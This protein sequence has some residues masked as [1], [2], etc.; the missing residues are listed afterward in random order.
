MP[1]GTIPIDL[2][3]GLLADYAHVVG[4]NCAA[5]EEQLKAVTAAFGSR[6]AVPRGGQQPASDASG[7]RGSR[8]P[9]ERSERRPDARDVDLRR[10]PARGRR[11]GTEAFRDAATAELGAARLPRAVGEAGGSCAMGAHWP[12]CP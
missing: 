11:R 12:P 2:V 6:V 10:P 7:R 3:E 1:N 8:V 4:I 9:F 5:P